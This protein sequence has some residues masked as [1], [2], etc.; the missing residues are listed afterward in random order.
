[1]SSYGLTDNDESKPKNLTDAEKANCKADKTGWTVPA[2]GN[3]NPNADRETIVATHRIKAAPK[4]APKPE[5]VVKK[6]VDA[7]VGEKK[8]DS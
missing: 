3:D 5:P 2:G 8:S 7:I 1:M 6:V 4:P